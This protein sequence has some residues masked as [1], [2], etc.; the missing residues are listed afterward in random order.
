MCTKKFIVTSSDGLPN[1]VKQ[2]VVL[3]SFVSMYNLYYAYSDSRI[4]AVKYIAKDVDQR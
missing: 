4:L 2:R 3:T 1:P